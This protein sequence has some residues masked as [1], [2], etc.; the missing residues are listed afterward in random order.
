VKVRGRS[1]T[2]LQG[3]LRV[4]FRCRRPGSGRTVTLVKSASGRYAA[5]LRARRGCR[6]ARRGVVEIAYGGDARFTPGRVA[7]TVRRR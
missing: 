5:T 6:R 4:T 2:G 3:R 1:A 7:R